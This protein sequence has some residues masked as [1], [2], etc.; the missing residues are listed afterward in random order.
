MASDV[1]PIIGMVTCFQG[2]FKT[3]DANFLRQTYTTKIGQAGGIPFL[4]PARPMNKEDITPILSRL[5]GLL[6]TGGVDIHP[7]LYGEEPKRNL[8]YVDVVRD[9]FEAA[10]LERALELD[11]PV[12]GICRGMQLLNVVMGGTLYQHLDE[13][14]EEHIQHMQK[15]G[16]GSGIHSVYVQ[17]ESFL[18]NIYGEKAFVNSFHHQAIK[19]LADDLEPIAWSKD[20]LIEGVY[21]TKRRHVFGVQWHPEILQDEESQKLFRYFIERI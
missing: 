14:V 1:K 15:A 12:F 13:E 3:G 21:H 6:L 4:L 7:K 20:R 2:V 9:E 8:N 5:D 10:L 19:D 18:N 11:M 16:D 17:D